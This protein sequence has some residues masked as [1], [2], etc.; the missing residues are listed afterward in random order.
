MFSLRP[1]NHADAQ[2][3]HLGQ[4][5]PSSSHYKYLGINLDARLTWKYHISMLRT[6]C[7]QAMY[8]LQ[9]LSNMRWG[10]DPY[11][12]SIL[13]KALVR[14]RMDYGAFLYGSAAPSHLRH[15]DVIQNQA[16]RFILGATKT[17][18]IV[19]MDAEAKIPPLR[20]RRSFLAQKYL[21]RLASWSNKIIIINFLKLFCNWRFVPS[22]K[23]LLSLIGKNIKI[24]LDSL[25]TVHGYP[26]TNTEY[27]NIFH[28][29]PLIQFSPE[30]NTSISLQF[31]EFLANQYPNH[32]VIYTD[33]SKSESGCG[34]ATYDPPS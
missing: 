31:K 4:P 28:R 9:A 13:Y 1:Y 2:I 3:F 24:L 15:L 34:A 30:N 19:A 18:P 12:L 21:I 25:P 16:L 14:S 27:F 5:I 22:K 11:T 10:G 17:T 20:F 7:S 29:W 6:K 23:P 32:R 26:F 8:I 33:G